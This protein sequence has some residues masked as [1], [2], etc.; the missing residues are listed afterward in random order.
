MAA[1]L[2]R[3][4]SGGDTEGILRLRRLFDDLLARDSG[5][6]IAALQALD[7]SAISSARQLRDMKQLGFLLLARGHNL[8]RQGLHGDCIVAF[9]EAATCYEGIGASFEA[10]KSRFMTSL[11]YRALGNRAK[12]AD[13]LE[14]VL[15][16]TA[17]DDSWRG[18]PLQVR[19][20]LLQDEG[21]LDRAGRL[22]EEALALHRIAKEGDILA[23]G[24]LADLGEI[25]GLQG[26]EAKARAHFEESLSILAGFEG[27]Y[28]RQ[29]A[30][31]KLKLAEL[32]IRCGSLDEAFELLDDADRLAG[33]YGHYYDLLWRIE[34][35]RSAALLRAGRVLSAIRRFRLVRV[36]RR[37][38][39]L[40]MGM[41]MRQ[42]VARWYSGSGLP[43]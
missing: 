11:A 13:V 20:W 25:C 19:A 27:Q 16:K 40:P 9:D 30:R 14:M 2:E 5:W 7:S 3:L 32:C 18:N 17:H 42:L 21:E 35:S 24:T 26:D 8:H 31:T 36:Y 12:A 38:L 6:G 4:E 1:V 28:D 29:V 33:A 10:L 23:A 15:S 41:L 37:A 34:L 43:R 39:G 22:L